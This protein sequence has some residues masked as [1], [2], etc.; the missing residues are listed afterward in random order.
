MIFRPI[1]SLTLLAVALTAC[2]SEDT[3]EASQPSPSVDAGVDSVVEDTQP[4]TQ[5][6]D[7][8]ANEVELDS[9]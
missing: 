7:D 9:P 3:T 2:P 4:E 8:V 5:V 1:P 6:L